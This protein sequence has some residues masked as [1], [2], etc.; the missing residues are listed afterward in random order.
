MG[1]ELAFLRER[2]TMSVDNHNGAPT[3]LQT[4][5]LI[6]GIAQLV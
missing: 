5:P 2:A 6:Q 1:Q 3:P 4:A